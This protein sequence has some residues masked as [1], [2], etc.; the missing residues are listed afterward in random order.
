MVNRTP[1]VS[2]V[3]PTYNRALFVTKAI[4]SVLKQSFKDYEIIVIDDGS[5][6]GTRKALEAYSNKI[7]YIYQENSGVSSARN[8]GIKEAKAEWMSFLDS[9]DEWKE[10][11][12]LVQM[13]QVKEVS[14]AVAHMTNAV[15]ISTNG[16]RNNFFNEIGLLNKFNDKQYLVLERPLQLIIN[17]GITFLQSSIIQRNILLRAGL[18]DET[19]TIAEDLDLITRVALQGPFTICKIELV[20]VYRR[21]ESIESLMILSMKNIIYKYDAFGKVYASLLNSPKLIWVEKGTIRKALSEN[22]RAMGN[23]LVIAGR[24]TEARQFY[25]ESFFWSLSILS[26]IKF[27]TTFL[28]ETLSR[29]L[30]RKERHLFH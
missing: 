10:N 28:P 25:K 1:L 18:L 15:S 24:K 13:A 19:L 12:L 14:N 7:T 2:V 11:Y 30:V 9:D 26:L 21:Q 27:L 3:I 8:T 17:H 22:K 4:D 5:T 6:D 16:E 23:V 29:I 20:E